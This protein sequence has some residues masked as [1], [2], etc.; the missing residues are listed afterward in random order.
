M[1]L[2]LTKNLLNSLSDFKSKDKD[3]TK[4]L[5]IQ[6]L[7]YQTNCDL[8]YLD[9][10]LYLEKE[11]APEKSFRKKELKK[12]IKETFVWCF[13][14]NYKKFV[15][16]IPFTRKRN[17]SETGL[18]VLREKERKDD[19][20]ILDLLKKEG[21]GKRIKVEIKVESDK[22][23]KKEIL[24]V[25]EELKKIEQ[26]L[27]KKT[28]EKKIEEKK[29]GPLFQ[30][31]K[32]E[33]KKE[34]KHEI[35]QYRVMQ[36]VRRRNDLVNPQ[37]ITHINFTN[38]IKPP[39]YKIIPE[40]MY[41]VIDSTKR[42]PHITDYSFDSDE[43]WED[44]EDA[45]TISSEESL[46]SEEEEQNDW[47]ESDSEIIEKT[48]KII[49][50]SEPKLFFVI[51]RKADYSLDVRKRDFLKEEEK[52]FLKKEILLQKDAKKFAKCFSEENWIKNDVVTKF[53]KNEIS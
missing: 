19:N 15:C 36:H 48:T 43:E 22:P 31:V 42:L 52:E 51:L 46:P 41:K 20:E 2:R 49:S 17:Q 8:E 47:L 34:E 37:R 28:E 5:L 33:E 38:R 13:Y 14:K 53:M 25:V 3:L 26:A 18:W 29:L 1:K 16:E 23:K 27:E 21:K 11:D 50:Y 32:K 4:D 45:E 35:C 39:T 6:I 9:E 10:I 30:F 40:K 12:L 24:E 7:N 44:C